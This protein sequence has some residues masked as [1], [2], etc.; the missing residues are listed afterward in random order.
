M[1]PNKYRGKSRKDGFWKYGS[2]IECDNGECLIGTCKVPGDKFHCFLVKTSTVG[3]YTGMNDSRTQ[4]EIYEHDICETP[5]GSGIVMCY[6]MDGII[7]FPV[8][9][10]NNR[11]IPVPLDR[12][13]DSIRKVSDIHTLREKFNT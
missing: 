13:A 11:E 8:I 7:Q 12:Y 4:E 6:Q 3:Q 9:K 2:L 10:F 5:D 1:K